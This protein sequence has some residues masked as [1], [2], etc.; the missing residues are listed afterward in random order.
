MLS[1]RWTSWWEQCTR[2][3]GTQAWWSLS[4]PSQSS[5]QSSSPS[6]SLLSWSSP[7]SS[8]SPGTRAHQGEDFV[9]AASWPPQDPG[10]RETGQALISLI[11]WYSQHIKYPKKLLL[12][13]RCERVMVGRWT[14]SWRLPLRAWSSNGL[15]RSDRPVLS[16]IG[17]TVP[18]SFIKMR[19]CSSST[20]PGGRGSFKRI[21]R[22]PL[23]R[24]QS[25]AHDWDQLLER[26]VTIFRTALSLHQR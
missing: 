22:R 18:A 16:Y 8:L 24:T 15:T 14:A 9:A 10:A 23:E 13:Q 26:K 17:L 7:S 19:A 2:C 12:H 5:A 11:I 20:H 25:W 6:S 4:W 21:S 3:S 1:N